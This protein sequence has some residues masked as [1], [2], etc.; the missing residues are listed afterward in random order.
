M[1]DFT[2][3]ELSEAHRALLS[4][5]KKCEK[6]EIG[7]LGNRSRRCLSDESKQMGKLKFFPIIFDLCSDELLD[8]VYML[9]DF[10]KRMK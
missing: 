4:T 8:D 1:P 7:K 3:E 9:V 6:I 10:R 5:L 2:L